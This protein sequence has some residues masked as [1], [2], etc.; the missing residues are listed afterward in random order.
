M[1][2]QYTILPYIT[3]YNGKGTEKD[4]E[5]AFLWFQ[6]A[7]EKGYEEL[8]HSL[9]LCYNNGEGTEKDLGMAFHW[10]Q[11]AAEKG[12]EESMHSLALC[13]NNGMQSTI[14]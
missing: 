1:K 14:Y 12:H 2:D 6:K 8:M 13:Y 11:K 4:L 9:A 3:T 7:S 5:M 10:F